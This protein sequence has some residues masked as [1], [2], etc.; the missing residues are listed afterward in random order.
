ACAS[1]SAPT[2]RSAPDDNATSVG[3]LPATDKD[4][5][6]SQPASATIT[7]DNVAPTAGVSGPADGVRGQ[8][9]TFTLTA[10]DPSSVDQAAGFTFS[11]TWGDGASQTVTGPSGTAVSH[12]YTATGTYTVKVTATDKDGGTSAAATATDKITAVALETDPTDSSKTALCVGGTT[13]ADTI[14]IKP[15][16]ANGTLNVKIGTTDLGNFKP[17]GHLIVYGQAGDDTLKL[18]TATVNGKTVYV[19]APAFLF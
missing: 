7:V 19:T 2:S 15:A 17:S 10:S 9:R 3:T 11:I 12:V 1:G 8:A 4:G 16:D 6:A 14:T 13:G 18:Q 5:G